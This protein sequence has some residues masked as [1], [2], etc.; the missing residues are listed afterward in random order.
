[1]SEPLVSL[2]DVGLGYGGK[3]VLTRVSFS[4][5]R[6]E[7]VGVFG[8]NGSG[9]STLL[10]GI[11]GLLPPLYGE[12]VVA[13]YKTR[14]LG[15]ARRLIGY[16]P[17]QENPGDFPATALDVVLMGLYAKL[18]WFH[19]SGRKER[20]QAREALRAVGMEEYAGHLFADLSAGQRQRVLLARALAA[21]PQLFLL[22]E[23]TSA[24]DIAAQ[25]SILTTIERLHRERGLTVLMVSH[26][27]NEIVHFCQKV[28]LVFHG[29]VGFGPPGEVLTLAN[30]RR[31]YGPR[32]LVYEHH[33]HPHVLVGDFDA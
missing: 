15:C 20:R 13:G 28:L 6:G 29:V 16:C 26:D 21:D 30:L 12:I 9:K 23:P 8:P 14:E 17:Q 5:A 18:G 3:P 24:V 33:G 7:F 32:V 31:I 1:M 4:V 27:I 25:A 11:L 22:D 10:K 19:R 2:R